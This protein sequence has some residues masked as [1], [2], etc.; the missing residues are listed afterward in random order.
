MMSCRSLKRNLSVADVGASDM[1]HQRRLQDLSSSELR[2]QV[3]LCHEHF[4][5]C[6]AALNGDADAEPVELFC[7]EALGD[8]D[9]LELF[10]ACKKVGGYWDDE[11]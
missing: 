5:R 7:D 11:Q 6:L 8:S 9:D 4:R 1:T 2:E 3:A 10:Y